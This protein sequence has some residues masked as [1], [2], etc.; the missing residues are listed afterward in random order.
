MTY[1][2]ESPTAVTCEQDKTSLGSYPPPLPRHPLFPE[3]GVMSLFTYV[4]EKGKVRR[5]LPATQTPNVSS[6]RRA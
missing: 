3:E 6:R 4:P 2:Q 1:Q 5:S